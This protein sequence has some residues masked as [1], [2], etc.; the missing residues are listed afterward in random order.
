[1]EWLKW[2]DRHVLGQIDT[3]TVAMKVL[4]LRAFHINIHSST[5]SVTLQFILIYQLLFH[6]ILFFCVIK[7]YS[8]TLFQGAV[9]HF[10]I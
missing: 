10:M 3:H 1:M 8:I 7:R 5:E 9:L 6:Q 2:L 4:N